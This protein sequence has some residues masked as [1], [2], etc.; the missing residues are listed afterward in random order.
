[1][2][3]NYTKEQKALFAEYQ[4]KTQTG[5]TNPARFFEMMNGIKADLRARRKDLP[6]ILVDLVKYSIKSD[7][8]PDKDK[9][10]YLVV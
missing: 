10:H 8:V 9:F 2:G 4:G 7:K 1:M 5:I 3:A 6:K